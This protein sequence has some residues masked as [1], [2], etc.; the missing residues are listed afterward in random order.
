MR[1]IQYKILLSVSL[2]F[3]GKKK[4]KKK[5]R[6]DR[7]ARWQ[8]ERERSRCLCRSDATTFH[9]RGEPRGESKNLSTKVSTCIVRQLY[10]RISQGSV[11]TE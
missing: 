3:Q 1:Y 5:K 8:A 10:R 6:L 9:D 2:I 4:K 7:R 11:E